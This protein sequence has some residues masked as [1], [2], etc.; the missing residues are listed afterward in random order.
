MFDSDLAKLYGVATGALNKQIRRLLS[1]TS[2]WVGDVRKI[3]G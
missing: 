1:F 2:N 3:C